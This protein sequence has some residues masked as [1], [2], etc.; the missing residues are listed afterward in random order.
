[1]QASKTAGETFENFYSLAIDGGEARAI[2]DGKSKTKLRSPIH[3]AVVGALLNSDN[4][5]SADELM[6]NC[7]AGKAQ[8]KAL[9]DKGILKVDIRR[10]ARASALMYKAPPRTDDIRLNAE[11]TAA[12]NEL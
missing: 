10:I 11:Q 1:M 3:K 4:P 5:L 2:L 9:I 12:F 6:L 7:S 8:F